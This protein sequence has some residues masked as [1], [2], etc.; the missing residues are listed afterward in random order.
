MALYVVLDTNVLVSAMLAKHGDS[1]T[2]QIL[3]KIME[4][5]ITLLLSQD[6]LNEYNEVLRRKKFSFSETDITNII[7]P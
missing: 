4:G 5:T 6:I 3:M 7:I 2:V 1:V